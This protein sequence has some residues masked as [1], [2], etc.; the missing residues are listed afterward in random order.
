MT[1]GT[2]MD[3]ERA[4]T[5]TSSPVVERDCL[6]AD[7]RNGNHAECLYQ[8]PDATA[9]PD[10]D[11]NIPTTTCCCDCHNKP[12]RGLPAVETLSEEQIREVEAQT[13]RFTTPYA[14]QVR[15][16][17]ASL[18]VARAEIAA[19]MKVLEPSMPENGLEDACRQRMQAYIT[20]RDNCETLE[21][22]LAQVEKER[23]ALRDS[24]SLVAFQAHQIDGTIAESLQ[25]QERQA[26][27]RK[28]REYLTDCRDEETGIIEAIALELEK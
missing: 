3:G 26:C 20:E 17:C 1:T 25:R 12:N 13:A 24:A 22:R 14:D 10:A 8:W 6:F 11:G 21:S 7:C 15:A 28:V 23:D 16:L 2:P 4:M 9:G 18:R 27:A 5:N 19:A